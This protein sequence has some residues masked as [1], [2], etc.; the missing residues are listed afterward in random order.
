MLEVVI[1]RNGDNRFS[2]MSVDDFMGGGFLDGAE[3]DV[4]DFS[5]L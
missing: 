5:P 2:G 4:R 3:D 1:E